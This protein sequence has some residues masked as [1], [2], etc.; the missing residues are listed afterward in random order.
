[1]MDF[2]QAYCFSALQK[3]RSFLEISFSEKK[4]PVAEMLFYYVKNILYTDIFINYSDIFL[5]IF[6]LIAGIIT[7]I[8]IGLYIGNEF[9]DV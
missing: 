1:M 6:L 3:S 5:D 2:L 7:A 8:L 4:S 9:S